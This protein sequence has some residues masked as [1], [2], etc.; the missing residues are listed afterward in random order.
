MPSNIENSQR[1]AKNTLLLYFRTFI[2]L[3][4]S[5]YTSRVILRTLGVE[6]FGIYNVVGGVIVMLGYLTNSLSAASSRYITYDLGKGDLTQMK[7]TFGNILTIHFIMAGIIILIAETIGLWFVC[8]QLNIPIERQYAAMWVYQ[9]AILSSVVALIGVPYNSAI[10]AHEKMSAFAYISIS[11]V[12]LKLIIACVLPLIPYDRLIVYSFLFL[13]IQ[14]FD[15]VMYGVY[16]TKHFEETK[17]HITYN[18]KLFKEIFNFA[19]WTMTGNIAAMGFSQGLNILLNIFFGPVVNAARGIAVQV[20]SAC[21]QFCSN[22]QMALNPQLTKSYAQENLDYM[23]KLLIKSSKFSFYI[24]FFIILPLMFE[25]EFVLKIWLGNVPEH[26]ADFLRLILITGLLYTLANPVI[27]S[28]HATG[29]I[30]KF[31]IIEGCMLLTIVPIAYLLLKFTQVPPESVFIV[32]II[33]ETC[34]QYVRLRIIL[35]MIK[36]KLSVYIKQVIFPIL[37]VIVLSPLIPF[38]AYHYITNDGWGSFLGICIVCV[39]CTSSIIYKL[40]CTTSERRFL[41]EKAKIFS[42]KIWKK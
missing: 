42:Q 39:L 37:V 10:I 36:L 9:F 5:L 34:T 2:V 1:I 28:V 40:G 11:D 7:T 26:T 30:K 17:A 4:I 6:D 22:F 3:L 25:A 21:Q 20:Q 27:V 12:V 29:K 35:P 15:R 41:D 38:T 33:V 19:G 18:K 24:L 23:H 16:C 14:I 32:H 8:T 31:Q 13:C